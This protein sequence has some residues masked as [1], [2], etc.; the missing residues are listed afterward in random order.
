MA[1]CDFVIQYN[2]EKDTDEDIAKKIIYSIWVKRVKANKPNV[3]FISGDSGEGKSFAA[4]RVQELLCSISGLAAK[5]YIQAMNVYTPLEYPKKL[6]ALL[7]NKSLKKVNILTVHE[8]RELV[9]SK[10]W[11]TFINQAIG[12]VNAMSRSIKRLHFIIVSQF[13]RDISSDIRYTLNYYCKV[14][15]PKGKRAR[16]YIN[17]MWKDDRDVEKPRLRKRRL[18]GYLIY[19]NGKRRQFM[20]KY[21]EL[22]KPSPETVKEFEKKDREAKEDIIK[23][24]M[25]KIVK[26]MEQDMDIDS[27]KVDAMID[28]YS[29]HTDKIHT[30]IKKRGKKI[31][32]NKSI[33]KMHDLSDKDLKKFQQGLNER[34]IKIGFLNDEKEDTQNEP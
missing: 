8:A 9:K 25:T 20:P 14:S 26:E 22:S 7:F 3:I 16:L 10:K 29:T 27:G 6:D 28:Y 12:D 21:L 5:D 23:R 13:I 32:I 1:F 17:V 11:H 2:P 4:L 31:Y 18:S 19:P 24:K 34:L 30:I 33:K 15:R